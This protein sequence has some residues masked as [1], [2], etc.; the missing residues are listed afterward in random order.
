MRSEVIPWW[1]QAQADL[2]TA[3]VTAAGDRHYATS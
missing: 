1:E 2:E 3:R